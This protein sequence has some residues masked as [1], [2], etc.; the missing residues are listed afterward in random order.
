SRDRGLADTGRLDADRRHVR[1]AE[2]LVETGQE[3][4]RLTALR[5]DRPRDDDAVDRLLQASD[6]LLDD[7]LREPVPGRRIAAGDELAR[8][9][10]AEVLEAGG[11]V[12]RQVAVEMTVEA[13]RVDRHLERAE[14][15]RR[16]PSGVGDR[17]LDLLVDVR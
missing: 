9:L 15:D 6:L 13:R 12:L 7:L 10:A 1:V 11:L 2:A 16:R 5:L 3:R 4:R 14:P 17:S 8:E